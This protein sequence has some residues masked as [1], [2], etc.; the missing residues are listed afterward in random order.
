MSNIVLPVL[1]HSLHDAGVH[2]VLQ[3]NFRR[4]VY[5][6]SQVEQKMSIVISQNGEEK[7]TLIPHQFR[8]VHVLKDGQL[9]Y[10]HSDCVCKLE[11]LQLV[12][13]ELVGA[14]L[15][16]GDYAIKIL[17]SDLTFPLHFTR[18]SKECIDWI[19]RLVFINFPDLSVSDVYLNENLPVV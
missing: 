8:R 16:T 11:N 5:I 4:R 12:H 19:K 18:D 10:S 15:S 9:K 14:V 1:E 3:G 6:A 2:A 17:P 13:I 7:I